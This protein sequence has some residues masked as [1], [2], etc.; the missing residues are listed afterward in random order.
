MKRILAV[1]ACAAAIASAGAEEIQERLA[2]YMP[3]SLAAEL[4]AKGSV[5]NGAYRQ[6]GISPR[7]AP[8]TSLAKEAL[9]FWDGKDAPFFSETLTL[10]KKAERQKTSGPQDR[11]AVSALL[12]SISKLQGIEYFSHSRN[13]MRTLYEKAY[14]VDGLSSKKRIPDPVSGSANGLTVYALQ[15]DLTFGEYVYKYSYRETDDS[16]AF[17]STNEQTMNYAIIK[18]LDPERLRISLVVQDL[19]DYF[20]VYSLTRADFAAIPGLEEKIN[21]SFSSRANAVYGWFIKEYEKR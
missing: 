6:K 20:L 8:S 13:K 4:V 7:L 16:V 10:Y 21:N 14:A 3:A 2:A 18:V 19:G 1:I 17:Y 12:R 5:Q 9:S 11:A 15:K